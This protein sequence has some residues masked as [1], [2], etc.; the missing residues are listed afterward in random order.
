M[1]TRSSSIFT[2]AG[3]AVVSSPLF[4]AIFIA[5]FIASSSVFA[6]TI[7]AQYTFLRGSIVACHL[8][9]PVCGTMLISGSYCTYDL[10]LLTMMLCETRLSCTPGPPTL[11]ICAFASHGCG[12]PTMHAKPCAIVVSLLPLPTPLM[13]GPLL[14][15]VAAAMTASLCRSAM[16]SAPVSTSMSS[17]TAPVSSSITSP[18]DSIT[19]AAVALSPSP[20]T[21]AALNLSIRPSSVNE[22]PLRMCSVCERVTLIVFFFILPPS[23][24]GVL[25]WPSSSS[26]ELSSSSSSCSFCCSI[27]SS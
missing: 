17:I 16:V 24:L 8:P 3:A 25:Q 11:S 14:V 20:L 12:M 27:C 5:I 4:S 7:F 21:A 2:S 22:L 13:P 1:S 26:E 23:V 6:Q 15:E 10:V 9:S 19:A 18:C